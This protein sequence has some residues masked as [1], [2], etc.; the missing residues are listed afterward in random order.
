MCCARVLPAPFEPLPP[1]R[2]TPTP[3]PHRHC[4]LLSRD[5]TD[6]TLAA[7]LAP[8][9]SGQSIEDVGQFVTEFSVLRKAA[10]AF[11]NGEDPN[12]V[13]QMMMEEQQVRRGASWGGVMASHAEVAS[14]LM[15]P[16]ASARC[17]LIPDS[18]PYAPCPFLP[19][20]ICRLV[21][22]GPRHRRPGRR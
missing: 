20:P 17:A 1:T 7:P 5:S 4:L 14:A 9:A 22:V 12:T 16:D 2:R 13:K 18:P 15:A 10:V 11:A 3:A 8:Q 6:S 21:A 19:V